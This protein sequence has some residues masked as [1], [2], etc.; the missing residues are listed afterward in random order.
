M[1]QVEFDK[2]SA[3][4]EGL[5]EKGQT[6][7]LSITSPPNQSKS[8]AASAEFWQAIKT[9]IG[10]QNQAPPLKPGS[11]NTDLPLSFSQ[12]RLWF[13]NQLKPDSS[14][15][16]IPL[17]LHLRGPLNI[18]ALEQSLNEILRRHET[19]RTTVAT[20][21]GQPVQVI[22]PIPD[23]KLAILDCTTI[24]HFLHE[25]TQRPFD[26]NSGPLLRATLLYLGEQ[27]HVL[28][29]TIHQ[30]VFDGWS[31]GVL[32]RELAALYEA[33]STGNPSSLPELPVQYADFALWQRQSLQGEL[34]DALLS[35]WKQ[36]LDG[37]LPAQ[38]LPIDHLPPVVPTRRSDRQ[39]LVL[40]Q[41]LTEAL[42]ALTRQE[43][44][45]LFATL[46]AAFKV[47]LYRYTAQENLFVCSPTANRNR[48]QTKG[49]I[50][51]FVNLLV[52]RT[53]L[54]GNPSFRQLLGQ[55]RTCA[56]GA[57]AHQDL[58]VQQLVNSL[59]LVNTPL[60]QVMF[61]LQNVPK[62]PLKLPGLTVSALEIDNGTADFDLSLSMVES[63]QE[64]IG[65]LKYNTDLFED[66]TITEML[67][68]Y[69]TLLEE[70]VANPEQ[71]IASLLPSLVQRPVLAASTLE[72]RQ[73][74]REFV[75]PRNLVELQLTE[76]WQEVLGIQ[77][78]GV[79][80]NFF[81][82]GGHSLL[83]VT[84]FT[85]IEQKFG[86]NLPLATLFQAATVEQLASLLNQEDESE[87][88]RSLVAIKP[89]GSKPP[90]FCVH[91]ILGNVLIFRNF[92]AHLDPEQPFYALQAQGL[93]GKQVPYTRIEE[94]A[95]HYIKE[96]REIQPEGPYYLGGYSFGGAIAFEM[97]QQ[98]KA[99]GQK[100]AWLGFFDSV[101]LGYRQQGRV[102][103]WV[104][105]HVKKVFQHGPDYILDLVKWK[106][107]QSLGIADWSSKHGIKE[108]LLKIVQE[109]LFKVAHKSHPEMEQPLPPTAAPA[110][111]AIHLE[112]IRH[113]LPQVYQG[114]VS[115]FRAMEVSETDK[116]YVDPSVGWKKLATE[117]LE[118]HGVPGDHT[119]MFSEP[120]VQALV[121]QLSTCLEMA[122]AKVR[123]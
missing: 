29:V 58:P 13:L 82:L 39:T 70:I 56:S 18:P 109:K 30:I 105:Q 117:G 93:D 25:Q 20:V 23:F 9:I 61:V 101:P 118:I 37:G 5:Q 114:R 35:Y 102:H 2:P 21:D 74:Q 51:Y 10:L 45:T 66:A 115:Y 1:K 15:H 94:M 107:K 98:L 80:D 112:T 60:N 88:W 26:L 53:D 34:K 62:Q 28:L 69:Q 54:S 48:S 86:K 108:T 38:Q 123:G 122:Q 96:I 104:L 68:H 99:Q 95:A 106:M 72:R 111:E 92:A 24:H 63:A 91:G 85:Q 121:E 50:G 6:S 17:G 79:K 59:N 87:S 120:Y 32:L 31:E 40:P 81:E 116:W 73:Q 33:F 42:K 52:L 19:L 119:T 14:A 7:H 12:E 71:P 4:P 22:H 57:F 89:S 46:L 77:P 43:G 41:S 76:I 90:L 103:E 11:R 27:E 83:A 64:L 78:I 3:L 65:V 67:R 16:N 97:A 44:A 84:L 113:Y 36:Q 47:L 49:L 55:V 8:E 75:A 110:L 100:I